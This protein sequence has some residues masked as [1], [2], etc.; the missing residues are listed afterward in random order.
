M[1]TSNQISK[2]LQ[3]I[4]PNYKWEFPK[5]PA[6]TPMPDSMLYHVISECSVKHMV[7]IPHI[8]ECENYSGRWQSNV[9]VFQYELW[10][11]DEYRPEWRWYV[12]DVVGIESDFMGNKIQ[13]SKNLIRLESGWVLFE[14]QTDVISKDYK[15]FTPFLGEA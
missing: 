5:N 15:S 9:E 13:H 8:W 3:E 6:W 10:Q 4:W 14:P 7:S 1:I 12:S 11:S 2:E